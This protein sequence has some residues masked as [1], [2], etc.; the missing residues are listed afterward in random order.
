VHSLRAGLPKED[1]RHK[2]VAIVAHEIDKI[3]RLVVGFLQYA[4]PP[5]AN[6]T[7]TRLDDVVSHALRLVEPQARQKHL[8]ISKRLAANLPDIPADAQQISQVLVNLLLNAVQASSAGCEIELFSR[9]V[10]TNGSAEPAKVQ[11]GV[12]DHGTGIA[13]AARDKVFTPFYTTKPDGCGL[14]LAISQRIVEDHG[15]ELGF[16]CDTDGGTT[17]LLT[18]PG[19]R[20]RDHEPHPDRG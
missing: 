13:M 18:L 1:P 20:G 3:N 16:A 4:Q 7:A 14:G 6:V 10:F 15:G 11:I 17:F 19:P 12:K 8:Q 5:R 2:D 9:A